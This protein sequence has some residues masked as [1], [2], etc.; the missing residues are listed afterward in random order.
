MGE[1]VHDL[2]KAFGVRTV[3]VDQQAVL[4]S[5]T[6]GRDGLGSLGGTDER[7]GQLRVGGA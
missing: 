5:R 7:L 6:E 4:A 2:F 1:G 3:D